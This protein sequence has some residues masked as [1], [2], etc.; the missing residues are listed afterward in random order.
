MRR[1]CEIAVFN[2]F[3]SLRARQ[4]NPPA[5]ESIGNR[6]TLIAGPSGR[7]SALGSARPRHGRHG[8][9]ASQRDA[10]VPL[11]GTCARS[12]GRNPRRG[13]PSPLPL[14]PSARS[15]RR[16]R[17][18]AARSPC[19]QDM[20]S[21]SQ[22]VVPPVCEDES[23]LS[24]AN[25]QEGE[26]RSLR[27][28]LSKRRG[29]IGSHAVGPPVASSPLE[30]VIRRSLRV[31][32]QEPGD[33]ERARHAPEIE[34]QLS[35]RSAHGATEGRPVHP[36]LGAPP[37][38]LEALRPEA[39]LQV[40]RLRARHLDPIAPEPPGE[41]ARSVVA[42]RHAGDLAC[43]LGDACAHAIVLRAVRGVAP[44]PFPLAPRWLTSMGAEVAPVLKLSG[45]AEIIEFT[46][47]SDCSSPPRGPDPH[48]AC[49]RS[50]N[51]CD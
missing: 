1:T 31:S 49:S 19:L 17:P 40:P 42:D 44:S 25:A 50:A 33:G 4:R 23:I 43:A 35:A 51:W 48:Q 21:S 3:H 39:E 6:W 34:P 8:H 7:R 14:A 24:C 16:G 26:N 27:L 15:P 28:A 47:G 22:T 41:L 10:P 36:A 46:G 5:M 30:A 29:P 45:T 9:H 18:R 32:L 2:P 38:A 13:C 37:A 20:D 12:Q 11:R